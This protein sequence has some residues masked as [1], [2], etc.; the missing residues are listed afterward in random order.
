VH[1]VE[2]QP[3]NLN[4]NSGP[5]SER[6]KKHVAK[7]KPDTNPNREKT[8]PELIKRGKREGSLVRDDGVEGVTIGFGDPGGVDTLLPSPATARRH[9]ELVPKKASVKTASHVPF[10][11]LFRTPR[12]GSVSAERYNHLRGA[13]K[14]FGTAVRELE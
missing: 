12:I 13:N 8:L 3:Q 1:H 14:D 2:Q 6:A 11:V 9:R 10:S 4:R 7:S 5:N